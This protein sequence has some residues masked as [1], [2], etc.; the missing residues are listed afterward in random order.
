MNYLDNAATTLPKPPRVIQAVREAMESMASPG[1]GGHEAAMRAAETVFRCREA[2]AEMFHVSAPENVVFTLNATH[3]LNLA[4]HT[5]VHRGTRVL[6]SGFEHNAVTRPLHA[7][8]ARIRIAGRRVFD[9]E[10]TVQSFQRE[11]CGA[12]LVVCTHVSNVFGYVLPIQEIA[13]LCQKHGVPLVV[14]ASQSAGILPIDM[15]QLGAAF[16]AMPGH[17]ALF[18]PQGTGM[19]LCGAPVKPLLYGGSGSDSI[20]QQMP[21]YL[22]DRLEAG[23]H[24]VCGIAGLL[25]GMETV[26][27][28]GTDT[29]AG[30]E[31]ELVQLMIREL[32][33]SDLVLFAGEGET[34]CGVLSLLSDRMDCESLAAALAE[35]GICVRS[36]LHCAPTAHESAGTLDSGTVRFSFSPYVTASQVKAACGALREILETG[37]TEIS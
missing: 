28:L 16:L 5:M 2:A 7:L 18:G 25:A 37:E 29:I 21:S 9:K 10:D 36:G 3:A 23:T 22:P 30:H 19:L 35:R 17:K 31:R 11:I 24:N 26:R 27:A 12:E 1:R 8:G 6:I 34:Q 20:M 13:Q 32:E 4:L 15:Q 14:D 33:D